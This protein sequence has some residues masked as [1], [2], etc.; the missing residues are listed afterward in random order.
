M[1]IYGVSQSSGV[2]RRLY[3]ERGA[4]GSSAGRR[5]KR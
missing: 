2:E 1:K 5:A 4:T 3:V